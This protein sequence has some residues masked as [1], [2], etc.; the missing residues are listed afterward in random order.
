MIGVFL[1]TRRREFLSFACEHL[2]EYTEIFDANDEKLLATFEELFSDA[3]I[4][5]MGAFSVRYFTHEP[6]EDVFGNYILND[7]PKVAFTQDRFLYAAD[8]FQK[9][10][11][12]GFTPAHLKPILPKLQSAV[13]EPKKPKVSL[14]PIEK[15]APSQAEIMLEPHLAVDIPEDP[16]FEELPQPICES[17]IPQPVASEQPYTPTL[18]QASGFSGAPTNF[19]GV[20][21]PSTPMQPDNLPVRGRSQV[22]S[23]RPRGLKSRGQ[24]FQVPIITLSSITDKSGVS[25]I[26]YLLAHAIAE[27][28]PT[29]KVLY[30]DLNISNPNFIADTVG[31]SQYTDA[32]I[33]QIASLSQSDFVNNIALLTETLNLGR[34]SVSVITFGQ[35]SFTQKKAAAGANFEQLLQALSNFFDMVIVDLGKLQ[36]TLGYQLELFKSRI[37]RHLLLADG[38]D[39]RLIKSFI[40]N[41]KEL[42]RTYE[43]VVNKYL[44]QSGIFTISQSLHIQ[45]LSTIGV[46]HNIEA[47]LTGRLPVE[48]TALY[49][50]L[51]RLGGIL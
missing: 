26:G 46:H 25:S 42:P 24:Q 21:S 14:Q 3:P 43:I 45:P 34:S 5:L 41:A 10:L 18:Q 8:F 47:Y 40:S 23:V 31:V 13:S 49:S 9:Y 15:I 2:V 27:Q 22:G 35:A 4:E 28:H 36:F 30:V 12:R 39:S 51:F 16:I 50:E 20:T 38:S 48:G 29:A 32:T 37:A 11:L 44:P 7:L 1:S 19:F 17:Q 33:M 6:L